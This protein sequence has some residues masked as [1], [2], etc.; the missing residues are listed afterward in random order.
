MRGSSEL[1][2][3]SPP[4]KNHTASKHLQGFQSLSRSK[5]SKQSKKLPNC[6]QR[7]IT[8]TTSFPHFRLPYPKTFS[9]AVAPPNQPPLRASRLLSTPRNRGP[10][11]PSQD[12]APSPQISASTQPCC[13]WCLCQ[14]CSQQKSTGTL[15]PGPPES[16]SP[17]LCKPQKGL[18]SYQLSTPPSWELPR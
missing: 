5:A 1:S 15:Q 14:D 2:P 3:P 10:H 11:H 9:Q 17:S 7:Q 18:I 16:I 6:N 4:K 12:P 8:E 13:I